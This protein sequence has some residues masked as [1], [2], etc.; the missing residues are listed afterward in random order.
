MTQGRQVSIYTRWAAALWIVTFLVGDNHGWAQ[1]APSS[2]SDL[3]RF[4]TYQSGRPDKWGLKGGIFSCAAAVAEAGDNRAAADALVAE[5]GGAA[6]AL[7]AALDSLETHGSQSEFA[8]NAGW[9]L[10][11]YARIKGRES[12]VRLS[13]M[14][15]KPALNFL[16]SGLDDSIATALDLTA[17]ISNSRQQAG[18]RCR[19]D[20]PRDALDQ[21]ILAWERDD[22]E[23]FDP[24]LGPRGK[25]ALAY[26]LNG[27]TWEEMRSGLWPARP[28]GR[29]AV[30]YRF[31]ISGPWAE[32]AVDFAPVG[33]LRQTG[34]EPERPEIETRFLSGGGAACGVRRVPFVA[35]RD[36]DGT[37]KYLVDDA[38]LGDF[39]RTLSACVTP[40][41]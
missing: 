29:V 5:G 25:A 24:R 1:P 36:I 22:S 39:L 41:G 15:G 28:K 18:S 13:K 37:A 31:E 19:R 4:L 38:D 9:L 27:R 3:I 11:V 2:P 40:P 17:Y 21:L 33:D 20:E 30:G 35:T 34:I 6:A 12:Y 10:L 16:Q 14:V 8:T 23:S 26:L 7:Q 32:P